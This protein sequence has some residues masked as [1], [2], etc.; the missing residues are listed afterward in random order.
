MQST[1]TPT[2][3]PFHQ[4][5][6]IFDMFGAA[7]QADPATSLKSFQQELP[8]FYSETMGY[9]IITRYEDVKAIFRD[10]ILFSA[11][12]VLEKLM[13]SSEVAMDVLR[14]YNYGMN[15][16]LVNEDEPIHMQRRRLLLDAFSPE[17]L[18]PH[19]AFVRQLVKDKVDS[20]IYKGKADLVEEMLWE[21]P[22]TVALHFL[23]VDEE[24]MIELRKFAVAHTVNTWGKPSLAD[25]MHVAEGVGRFWQFSG[26]LLTKMKQ[27]PGGKGWMYD[28]IAKNREAPEIV[29]DNYLHSMMMAIM[30]AAHETTS[31]ASTNAIKLL[32]TYR[33]NWQK[34]CENPALIPAAVEEC[35]RHSGS[36]VAWRRQVKQDTVFNGIPFQAGDKLFL[37]MASANHDA[38]HFENPDDFDIYRDNAVEHLT[39]GYGAHQCMGKNIG[40]MEMCIFIEELTRRIPSLRLSEQNFTYLPNTSFRG[41][42][43][44]WVEWDIAANSQTHGELKSD[45]TTLKASDKIPLIFPI[46]APNVKSITRSVHVQKISQEAQDVLRIELSPVVGESLPNWQAGSHI[47]LILP[48]QLNRKYSLCGKPE[49]DFYTIVVKKEPNSRGGSRWIHEHLSINDILPIKGPKNF[50]K[51]DLEAEFHLLIAGGIG[52]TPILSMANTLKKLGKTYRLLYLCR[53]REQMALLHEVQSHGEHVSYYISSEGNRLDLVQTLSELPAN[54]PVCACGSENLLK[55]LRDIESNFPSIQLTVEHFSNEHTALTRPD[56]THFLVELVDS[57]ITIDVPKDS[58]LLDCLLEK[59]I[60]VAY[61]CKEGLCGSCQVEVVAGDIDHRDQVL[62]NLERDSMRMMMSCCSRGKGK[63]SIKL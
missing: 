45:Q 44:L 2:G 60:D 47:E 30:V 56:D 51:L 48:N 19:Q 16:T 11:R 50:F 5:G 26:N 1:S 17:A 61:D 33:Q 15:R 43:A 49:D 3:C 29:T 40:R 4:A 13:P 41:P 38:E 62:N 23:G 9:W 37:V 21:V 27:N 10:P 46:G 53:F 59:G 57:D 20:F 18:E 12:N 25:Q 32:L 39:F 8:I 6:K 22:L 58:T 36:V 42:E 52:I 34:I 31:L 63:I 54:T 55:T 24:D 7:Y 14:H 35:L 28:M